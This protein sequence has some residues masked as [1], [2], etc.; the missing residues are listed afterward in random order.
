MGDF[1]LNRFAAII[2]RVKR[3]EDIFARYGGE[4]FVM[5]PVGPIHLDE[6]YA[7]SERLRKAIEISEFQFG[8]VTIQL[9]ASFGFHIRNI[10]NGDKIEPMINDVIKQ[11][12]KA[13]YRAKKNGRNRVEYLL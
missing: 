9:T 13:L 4:E 7:F 12:D 6:V 8:D 5:I 3:K 2:N 11:A 1:A 10:T